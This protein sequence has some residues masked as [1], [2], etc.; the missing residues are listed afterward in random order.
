M[1]PAASTSTSITGG[2]GQAAGALNANTAADL[3][4]NSATSVAVQTQRRN[5]IVTDTRIRGY[6][7]GQYLTQGDGGLFYPARPDLDTPVSKFD[8]GSI[9]DVVIVKGPYSVLYGPG[10]AFLDIATIDSPRYK[11]YEWHGR[12]GLGYQTNG[13]RWDAIQSVAVGDKD[14]GFRLT[15]NY[16]Q[17][18]DY[19]S[20]DGTKIPSSYLSNTTSFALGFDLSS[21]SK[22][23]FKGL[24]VIQNGVEFP[25]LYFDIRRLDADAYSGRYT[26][27]DQGLFDKFTFDVWYNSTA[28]SGDTKNG[29]KQAFVQELLAASFSPFQLTTAQRNLFASPGSQSTAPGILGNQQFPLFADESNTRFANRSIGYRAAMSWGPK[30][31]PLL[32]IGNDLNV[33]GQGLV[34]DIRIRQL[35]GPNVNT[36]A[37]VTAGNQ[38]TFNQL[39]RVPESNQIDP[40]LFAQFALPLTDRLKLRTGGRIDFI[41]SSSNPRTITGNIDLFGAPTTPGLPSLTRSSLD[42]IVYSSNPSNAALTRTYTLLAGFV[43][44]EYKL[45][46]NWTLLT[47][48]GHSQRPPTL[49]ELY[50]AGPFIGVLQ[51]GTS[52]L[53]GDPNLSPE[54]L[55]QIDLGVQADYGVFQAGLNG[56]YAWI[57]DYITYDVNRSG[58][59]LTQ[60][61]Y[62]N[63]DRATLAGAE[64]FTQAQL[65][66]WLTPFGTISYVQGTDRT[67]RDRRRSAGL[68]SSR[69][70][71]PLTLE[72]KSESEPLPQIPPLDARVGLRFHQA[73]TTPKW[74]VEV[75]A[76]M[77]QRQANVATSLGELATPGF[78]VWNLRGFWQASERMLVSAGVENFGNLNYREH[79][80][81]ISGNNLGVGSLFRPGTNFFFNTQYSY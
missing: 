11:S 4:T 32:T 77:V 58:L 64:F 41:H 2:G 63:T 72:R 26:L 71:N 10:F 78:T 18:N 7:A 69:R 30:D 75:S 51:Q 19:Q 54:R 13:D 3:L 29:A 62:T 12:T 47:A 17:G 61:V 81:P 55:T 57:D 31:D 44:G 24:H 6:R 15:H 68:A 20:G 1:T 52:R 56:Y 43:Q 8:P 79:L 33:L 39:Q 74:Q 37:P 35:Q 50:A 46:E 67:A 42:P 23:E 70:D 76:R 21:K 53:I 60:V 14:W 36:G 34:E 16:L 65:T 66:S 40:G 9:R 49:N 80:D 48:F 27:T 38:P 28:A 22:V 25:G 45:D 59:G 73:S 5:A